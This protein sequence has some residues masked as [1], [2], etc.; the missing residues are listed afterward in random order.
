MVQ[1]AVI[2]AIA[3][4]RHN[5]QLTYNR[6]HAML[7]ALG[8][9]LV[10]RIMDRLKRS[11]ITRYTVIV[12][13][14]EGLVASY[15]NDHWLPDVKVELKYKSDSESLANIFREIAQ[16]TDDPF[17]VSG[18]NTFT[19][20]RFPE[21]MINHFEEDQARLL[22]GASPKMLSVGTHSTY[23]HLDGQRIAAIN[24]FPVRDQS[25]IAVANI[26]IC[27][28]DMVTFLKNLTDDD[29]KDQRTH[30]MDLASQFINQGGTGIIAETAW[31]LQIEAD[32]D[33]LTLNKN[34]LD[35]ALDANILSELPYTV[36]IIPPVR[37]DP[38]VSVGQGAQIGPHVY[39]ER[40]SSVG[41]DVK[42]KNAIILQRANVPA[43]KTVVDTIIS[44]RGPINT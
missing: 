33:L 19:H 32:R 3:H 37:I 42:I 7:P 15:L 10:V 44:T 9:P 2:I 30:F 4:P 12:G 27:G 38:Q 6:V 39:L 40:G 18:Y 8:K 16:S 29:I 26:A 41:R 24:E 1:H 43:D 28:M 17:M 23:A 13:D 34:L 35:E 25:N 22:I 20:S 5:S 21:S 14:N 36:Q 31:L 11:G